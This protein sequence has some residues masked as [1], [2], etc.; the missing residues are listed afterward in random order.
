MKPILDVQKVKKYFPVE[1]GAIFR[2]VAGQIK[3][4]DNISF[5]IVPGETLALVGESGCGKST[6]GRLI[7]NLLPVT[8]GTIFFSG[9]PLEEMDRS[10]RKIY[11]S[12]VQAVFQDPMS[13]LS[14]RMRIREIIAEGLVINQ[15]LSRNEIDSKI[16]Q[17]LDQ[18]GLPQDA[19]KHYPHEFSGG[20]RQRIAIAR[21]L[22]VDP[23][24]IILDEAVSALDVSI[25]AQIV[26]LLRDLQ[27]EF[28]LSYLFIAHS[29]GTVR[30]ISDRIGVMYLGSLVEIGPAEEIFTNL[31]HPY[32]RALIDAAMPSHPDFVRE[33]VVLAGEVPSAL[34]V[35]EGCRF[36]TRCPFAKD[37]CRQVEPEMFEIGPGHFTACHMLDGAPEAGFFLN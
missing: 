32:T 24:L 17:V 9:I 29:L 30:Y 26:N 20:Q 15:S 2:K 22:I 34:N 13:S 7:L 16:Q 36:N 23:K 18:V 21:A 11:R 4:V 10:Q 12:A 33:D 35:P 28:H 3:A 31:H 1:R 27:R 6:V 5:S 14:P 8:G 37:V 19:I 25:Q